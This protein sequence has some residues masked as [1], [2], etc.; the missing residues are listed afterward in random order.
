MDGPTFEQEIHEAGKP[1]WSMKIKKENFSLQV[2][3]ECKLKHW[4]TILP[5]LQQQA[6][7]KSDCTICWQCC[8]AV[9]LFH[10][11]CEYKLVQPLRRAI[12]HHQVKLKLFKPNSSSSPKIYPSSLSQTFM[13][14]IKP[15]MFSVYQ[16]MKWI[17]FSFMNLEWA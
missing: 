7:E 8:G 5:H 9:D 10:C 17:N 14:R 2:I 15:L 13:Q 11:W 12:W 4:D 16:C 1:K 3:M 6:F